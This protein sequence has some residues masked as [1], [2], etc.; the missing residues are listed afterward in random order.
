MI[1]PWIILL[2]PV[3][4]DT[5]EIFYRLQSNVSDAAS[6]S[7]SNQ[8]RGTLKCTTWGHFFLCGVMAFSHYVMFIHNMFVF[9]RKCLPL[10]SSWRMHLKHRSQFVLVI[11]YLQLINSGHADSSMAVKK[12]GKL[13]SWRYKTRCEW[14]SRNA[15]KLWRH[16]EKNV[17]PWCIS[18]YH[19]IGLKQ[20]HSIKNVALKA[21]KKFVGVAV[22]WEES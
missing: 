18:M 2:F 6:F 19:M 9:K 20:T 7:I 14:T 3:D 4:R 11:F 17:L 8:S 1:V 5:H 13:S 21:S 10:F 16:T 15:K 12:H 22:Y